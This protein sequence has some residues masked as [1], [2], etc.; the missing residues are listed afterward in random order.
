MPGVADLQI[1]NL[2]T[3]DARSCKRGEAL[4]FASLR[5]SNSKK[6]KCRKVHFMAVTMPEDFPCHVMQY[7]AVPWSKQRKHEMIAK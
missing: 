7:K 2:L 3:S 6:I 5:R 4:V 1:F